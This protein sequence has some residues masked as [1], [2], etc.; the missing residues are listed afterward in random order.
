MLMHVYVNFNGGSPKMWVYAIES[1]ASRIA[2]GSCF[3]GGHQK[4]TKD[5][6]YGLRTAAEKTANGYEACGRFNYTGGF[7]VAVDQLWQDLRAAAL[8][9]VS[10]VSDRASVL[11]AV[12]DVAKPAATGNVLSNDL[13]PATPPP[14]KAKKALP[15]IKSVLADPNS[16]ASIFD[17]W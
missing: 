8:R 4:S 10:T 17:G 14:P 7:D 12:L 16:P 13:A 11:R 15:N 9:N 2:W 1:G 3:K 5:A 6:N